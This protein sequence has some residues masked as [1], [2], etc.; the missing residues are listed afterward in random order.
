MLLEL[1]F[2]NLWKCICLF[3]MSVRGIIIVKYPVNQLTALST[4]VF[5]LIFQPPM[6][7]HCKRR[8]ECRSLWDKQVRVLTHACLVDS[9]YCTLRALFGQRFPASD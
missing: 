9:L 4:L 8:G 2:D 6:L 1:D 3:L 7:H 5:T